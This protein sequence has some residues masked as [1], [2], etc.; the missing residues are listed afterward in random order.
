MSIRR[1]VWLVAWAFWWLKLWG[2]DS[3]ERWRTALIAHPWRLRKEVTYLFTWIATMLRKL[4]H[5]HPNGSWH[6]G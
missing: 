5:P 2:E 6:T 3:F 4:L 1:L